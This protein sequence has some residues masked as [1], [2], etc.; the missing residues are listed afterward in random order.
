MVLLAIGRGH[1]SWVDRSVFLQAMLFLSL[2]TPVPIS[3]FVLA[4]VMLVELSEHGRRVEAVEEHEWQCQRD[5]C[6]V[7]RWQQTCDG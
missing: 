2:S 1:R 5:D 4:A 7:G 6:P 3:F